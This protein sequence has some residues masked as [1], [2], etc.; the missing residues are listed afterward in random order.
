MA[1]NY[2]GFRKPDNKIVVA[3]TDSCFYTE[4]KLES[5]TNA[6]AGRLAMMG[7]N[8]DDIVVADGV[9]YMPHG[10]IGY[11]QSFLGSTSMTSNRPATVDTIWVINMRVPV[12]KG[13]GF[14]I[15]AA[16]PI[17]V[18]IKKGDLLAPWTGGLLV[19]VVPMN[20]GYGLRVPFSKNTTEVDTGLDLPVGM[21]VRDVIVNVVTNASGASIDVGIG[22]GTESGFDADGFLDGES[23]ATAGFVVHTNG[24]TTEANNTLGALLATALKSGDSTPKYVDVPK[25]HVGDGTATSLCYTTSDHTI[26]GNMYFIVEGAGFAPVAIAEQ[27]IATTA[28]V[29]D[30]MVRSLI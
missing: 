2:F 4:Y 24:D 22:M 17:G 25:A 11:E 21:T 28:A 15:V 8:E 1:Q 3:A 6:Y 7:T 27:N 9:T 23:C 16:V 10:F 18:Q 30:V 20:G 5:A 19:P 12:L 14:W 13:G 29:T 26:A